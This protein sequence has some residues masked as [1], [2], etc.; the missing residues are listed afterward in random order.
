MP[1][2]PPRP[3][4]APMC[5]GKTTH[6]HGYCDTHADQAV[7]W[8]KPA[9]KKSGRGGRPWRRI[10]ER[11][12]Q[13]DKGLCQPCL[14]KGIYTPAAEVDHIVNEASGG[15]DVDDNLEAICNPCHKAKTQEEARRGRG[16]DA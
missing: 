5:A 11:I 9:H 3:C 1:G 7:T 16:V 15:T 6:K 14:R 13:R 2:S 8:K 4:R 10:R 12:L